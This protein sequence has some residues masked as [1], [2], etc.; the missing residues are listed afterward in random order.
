[1]CL[2]E[3]GIKK[4]RVMGKID[5][6]KL[7]IYLFGNTIHFDCIEC[8]LENQGLKIVNGEIMQ[9][10]DKKEPKFKV[11]DKIRRKIPRLH[12]KDMQVARVE[13]NYYLCNHLGKFSS[14]SISFS[15][16][17]N[18][19]LVEQD[20]TLGKEDERICQCLIRDQEEALDKVRNSKCGH[21]EII[22]DLKETYRERIDW[23][24]SLKDRYTWKWKPS[25]EK[26]EALRIARDRNDRTGSILS[27]LYDDLKKL[28]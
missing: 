22:A 11:G 23:L 7:I 12:D 3:S 14:E 27:Q 9:I 25:E 5:V 13:R 26:M 15:E 6:D 19:E 24:K 4:E 17:S 16:E 20:S 8:A 10:E 21:S 18:Y 28:M 1:M 2:S